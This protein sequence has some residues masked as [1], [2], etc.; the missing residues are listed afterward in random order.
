M[1]RRRALPESQP[2][3]SRQP[4][5][6]ELSKNAEI[7]TARGQVRTA[8][9]FIAESDYVFYEPPTPMPAPFLSPLNFSEA[10]DDDSIS[11][12]DGFE[13]SNIDAG[14]GGSGS[15]NGV[16]DIHYKLPCRWTRT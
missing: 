11:D 1:H 13:F 2:S 5:V 10:Y 7:K 15:E 9:V 14:S 4:T 16:G 12:T 3:V 8:L 6:R